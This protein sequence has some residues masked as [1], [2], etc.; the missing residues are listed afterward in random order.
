MQVG[1]HEAGHMGHVHHQSCADRVGDLAQTGIV[2]PARVGAS[3]RHDQL[4]LVL[5]GQGC[6]LL[7]VDP[8]GVRMDA[9]V[10]EMIQLAA[11]VKG[12]AVG[13]MAAV[14]KF[15]CQHR[16][17]RING[18]EIGRG[19][20]LGAGVRLDIGMIGIEQTRGALK[21]CSSTTLTFIQPP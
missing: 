12:G 7:V 20:S 3:T 15:Q 4:R 10:H 5:Q 6:H 18:G 17:A 11:E 1:G 8:L 9:V 16:V 19:V 13:Q 21:R 2:E 14:I